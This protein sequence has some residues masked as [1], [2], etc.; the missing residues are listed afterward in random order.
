VL[1]GWESEYW[2]AWATRG[3]AVLV[4]PLF[5]LAIVGGSY[6]P[7]TT[8]STVGQGLPLSRLMAM[9]AL[10]TV[11]LPLAAAGSGTKTELYA[12]LTVSVPLRTA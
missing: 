10:V 11:L 8:R 2:P 1:V 4:A 9:V 12:G 5:P 7:P 6:W 3:D